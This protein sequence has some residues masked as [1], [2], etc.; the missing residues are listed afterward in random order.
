MLALTLLNHLANF[1]KEHVVY[2]QT[3]NKLGYVSQ[4]CI[5]YTVFLQSCIVTNSGFLKTSCLNF[6]RI[7]RQLHLVHEVV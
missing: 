4:Y 7:Y 2:F 5:T 6:A 3:V 1:A